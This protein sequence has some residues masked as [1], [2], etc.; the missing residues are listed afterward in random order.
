M[1]QGNAEGGRGVADGLAGVLATVFSPAKLALVVY[2]VIVYHGHAVSP[3]LKWYV[4]AFVVIDVLHTDVLRRALNG[5]A[6]G[7]S[8]RLKGWG[9]GRKK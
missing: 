1:A 6:E 4:L 7:W 2:A 9:A 5:L 3:H 8:E